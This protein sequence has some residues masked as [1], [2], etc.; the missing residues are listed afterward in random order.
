MSY[1]LSINFEILSYCICTLSSIFK[2]GSKGQNF[3]VCPCL[4]QQTHSYLY[5]SSSTSA[6][7]SSLSLS[8]CFEN[9]QPGDSLNFLPQHHHMAP[10]QIEVWV[11][12]DQFMLCHSVYCL[13][14]FLHTSSSLFFHS[15]FLNLSLSRS[16]IQIVLWSHFR[17]MFRVSM[18][19]FKSATSWLWRSIFFWC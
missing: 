12:Q 15:L 4:K 16:T 18:D 13:P 3:C 19:Y 7:S 11:W 8:K 9:L 10:P 17:S 2:F 14:Q 1:L 5:S 6:M